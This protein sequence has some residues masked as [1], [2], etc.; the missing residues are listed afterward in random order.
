MLEARGTYKELW[1]DWK[2]FKISLSSECGN[3]EYRWFGFD[4][5][6]LR[7]RYYLFFFGITFYAFLFP[8]I[9][10]LAVQ[11]SIKTNK[12]AITTT[13]T[14]NTRGK[15]FWLY[16]FADVFLM[17]GYWETLGGQ[18]ADEEAIHTLLSYWWLCAS[19]LA[20]WFYIN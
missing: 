17:P 19:V 11:V 10:V 16:Q 9:L 7:E 13:T 12:Q 14:K 2:L 4:K 20:E 6:H 1:E 5:T 3:L 18:T 8:K 15:K